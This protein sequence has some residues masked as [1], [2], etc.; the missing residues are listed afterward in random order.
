SRAYFTLRRTVRSLKG[1]SRDEA[2]GQRQSMM[3]QGSPTMVLITS[4]KDQASTNIARG[5]LRNHG[6][7]STKIML[8]GQPVFQK[9]SVLLATIDSEI[10]FPPDLDTYFNPQAYIFLSRHRA[11]S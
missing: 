3:P 8:L 11:E 5:L 7:E 9:D 6:F 4:T 1:F 2:S 10:I